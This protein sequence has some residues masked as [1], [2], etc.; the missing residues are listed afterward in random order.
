VLFGLF[1]MKMYSLYSFADWVKSVG[2]QVKAAE[3]LKVQQGQIS[4]WVSAG[5]C[6]SADGTVY[7]PTSSKYERKPIEL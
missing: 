1:I 3:L 4:R 7:P 2:G 6:I 5:A